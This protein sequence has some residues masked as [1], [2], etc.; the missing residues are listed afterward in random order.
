MKGFVLDWGAVSQVCAAHEDS[1]EVYGAPRITA[2]LRA[3]TQDLVERRAQIV[4]HALEHG[5]SEISAEQAAAVGAW[6][7]LAWD[8]MLEELTV[9]FSPW[10]GG[11]H[12]VRGEHGALSPS[13]SGTDRPPAGRSPAT[14]SA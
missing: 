14:P 6:L 4:T 2:E 3:A 1:D 13:S 5:C 8:V 7:L 12:G 11:E 10:R 9:V